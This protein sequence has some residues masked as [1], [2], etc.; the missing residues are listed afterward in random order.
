M[1][2]PPFSRVKEYECRAWEWDKMVEQG[3]GNG[4]QRTGNGE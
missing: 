2:Q 4:E 1:K 3:T